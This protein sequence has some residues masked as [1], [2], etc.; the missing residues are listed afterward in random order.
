MQIKAKR[1]CEHASAHSTASPPRLS[2]LKRS[3]LWFF[4]MQTGKQAKTYIARRARP[5]AA[6][7]MPGA[8]LF[9]L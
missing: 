2:E 7:S 3:K 4:K 8:I 5:K 1:K 6:E 9:F